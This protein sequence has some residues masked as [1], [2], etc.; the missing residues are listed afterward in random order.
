M[1]SDKYEG[2]FSAFIDGM[3]YDRVEE[4]IYA[5][6]RAAFAAGWQAAEGSAERKALDKTGSSC[7]NG[8]TIGE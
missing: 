4:G 1:Y 2:A 6:V 7:Y 3:E 8:S 5:L